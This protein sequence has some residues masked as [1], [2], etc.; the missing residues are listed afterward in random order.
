M[1]GIDGTKI[2]H[3]DEFGTIALDLG[4]NENYIEQYFAQN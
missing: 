3:Q 4:A 2:N 1:I